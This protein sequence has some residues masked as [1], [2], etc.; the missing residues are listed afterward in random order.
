MSTS[1]PLPAAAADPRPA[2]PHRRRGRG[3]RLAAIGVVALAVLLLG[4]LALLAAFG[5]ASGEA[6]T[7]RP[8][9][10]V[11]AVEVDIDAGAVT[12]TRA[13]DLAVTVEGRSGRLARTPETT[14]E[15]IDGVLR[16]TGSCPS[17]GIGRCDTAVTVALPAGV[18]LTVRSE[19]GSIDV[20]GATAG[21]DLRST[22]GSIQVRGVE[23]GTRLRSDAGLI[24]GTVAH[25]PVEA[26]TSAG[27][28][29]LA[30]TEDV[31]RVSA[32]TEVGTVELT[33]PDEVYAVD[34]RTSLGR[35]RVEVRTA[36]DAERAISAR[37]E[38]GDVTVRTADGG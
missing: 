21:A 37:S 27:R 33:V 18:A 9:A 28:I 25:G 35:S 15:V 30:I 5:T 7:I 16:V 8:T 2:P 1:T 12:A 4:A 10:A 36:E 13:E 20:T 29:S 34:A 38:V 26:A 3:R 23:G 11:S 17:L 14:S 19:A 6:S 32:S 31:S 22:A 24:A